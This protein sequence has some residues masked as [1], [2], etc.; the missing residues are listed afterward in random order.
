[1]TV[2]EIVPPN[3]LP[4]V[5]CL[6]YNGRRVQWEPWTRAPA[7]THIDPSCD[8]CS[9]PGPTVQA[10]GWLLPHDGET[11][12]VRTRVGVKDA[13]GLHRYV[14]QELA[15]VKFL[16]LFASLCPSCHHLEV[17]DEVLRCDTAPSVLCDGCDVLC[18]VGATLEEARANLVTLGRWRQPAADWDLCC[19]CNPA[20]NPEPSPRSL[21]AYRAAGGR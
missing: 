11:R 1:M 5:P 12:T 8:R 2:T 4:S 7:M 13:S 16:R 10:F 9:F 14:K 15:A 6:T 18:G 19:S 21:A 3:R 17:Y 20:T